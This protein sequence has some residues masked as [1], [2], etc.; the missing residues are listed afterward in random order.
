MENDEEK[1]IERQ[2]APIILLGDDVKITSEVDEENKMLDD[3]QVLSLWRALFNT[4]V[5]FDGDKK[6]NFFQDGN[7]YVSIYDL[8][9]GGKYMENY[10]YVE[11]IFKKCSKKLLLTYKPL[12]FNH[13]AVI[14]TNK[15]VKTLFL[16]TISLD[17]KH[18]YE[19]IDFSI[20]NKKLE[21][22]IENDYIDGPKDSFYATYNPT[23]IDSTYSAIKSFEQNQT[24]SFDDMGI[25]SSLSFDEFLRPFFIPSDDLEF[26]RKEFYEYIKKYIQDNL[27]KAIDG[28]SYSV[29]DNL[30]RY[31]FSK[32]VFFETIKSSGYIEKYGNEFLLNKEDIRKIVKE[33]VP[34]FHTL[35]A[36]ETEGLIDI[37]KMKVVYLGKY[38]NE[39]NEYDIL[40]KI[41][42]KI[43][44]LNNEIKSVYSP[45]QK[46]GISFD[47]E[48]A[49]LVV[50]NEVCQLPPYK[51]E[52]CLCR[53]M[54]QYRKGEPV[55]WSIVFEKMNEFSQKLTGRNTE[56]DR[57]SVQDTMYA[58]NTRVREKYNTEEELF[59]WKSNTISR[60]F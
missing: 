14:S 23:F 29:R 26:V 30:V 2:K 42:D 60:N 48:K 11:K 40:I 16:N 21:E 45:L 37:K 39:P 53:V 10:L 3:W 28:G 25:L 35:I 12:P 57:R 43:K 38:V 13:F 54:Y 32:K 9:F 59:A 52:H 6:E 19:K 55:D 27:H 15:E 49:I 58:I 36:L 20:I 41:N 7:E 8:T 5:Y 51:N 22:V 34:F 50:N 33:N 24:I 56:K 4:F 44:A 31:E 18:R 1:R 17:E 46:N 47:N